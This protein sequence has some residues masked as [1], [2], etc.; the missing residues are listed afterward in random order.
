MGLRMLST[1]L[2]LT[3]LRQNMPPATHQIDLL[4]ELK[5]VEIG[6]EVYYVTLHTR[7]W[8]GAQPSHFHFK[9]MIMYFRTLEGRETT[10]YSPFIQNLPLTSKI[11]TLVEIAVQG[12]YR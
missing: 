9:A 11:C 4:D 7:H 5:L 10:I 12:L 1:G 2:H 8:V 3:F 6:R